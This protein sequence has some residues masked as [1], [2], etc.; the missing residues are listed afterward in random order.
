M[1]QLGMQLTSHERNK[2]VH[3]LCHLYLREMIV[4]SFMLEHKGS[5]GLNIN[6]LIFQMPLKMQC[7][8]TIHITWPE[9]T[10]KGKNLNFVNK[11]SKCFLTENKI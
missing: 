2:T 10:K 5:L 8:R 4:H 6:S 1:V 3:L 11:F 9:I 7:G